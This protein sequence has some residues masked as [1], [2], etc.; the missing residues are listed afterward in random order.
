MSRKLEGILGL[1]DQTK[2]TL[3][4]FE[5]NVNRMGDKVI[6]VGKKA[7]VALAALGVTAV[8]VGSNY[9][10][11][12]ANVQAVTNSTDKEMAALSA[13]AREMG[14][15]TKFSASEAGDAF[16]ALGSAGMSAQE[17]IAAIPGVLA[18]AAAEGAGLSE[19]TEAV[20]A[21]MSMF[22]M[23][24]EESARVANLFA[25]GVSA[26]LQKLPDLQEA[27]KNTGKAAN[28]VNI[29]I[30]MTVALITEFA[31][32]GE[33]GGIA[34]THIQ[35]ALLKLIKPTG[36]LAETLGDANLANTEFIDLLEMLEERGY[37]A[38][39]AMQDLG[40]RGMGLSTILQIGSKSIR[41]MTE[42]LTGTETASRK[43]STEM[44]T[45][46]GDLLEAKAA[47]ED[48]GIAFFEA[49]GPDLRQLV[50]DITEDIGEFG[51]YIIDNKD[52]IAAAA[53]ASYGALKEGAEWLIDHKGAIAAVITVMFGAATVTKMWSM[54]TALK[55]M[56]ASSAFKF[57]AT[58]GPTGWLA[59][60]GIGAS[61]LAVKEFNDRYKELLDTGKGT[62]FDEIVGPM[63]PEGETDIVITITPELNPDF[64]WEK[65]Y[66]DQAA[67][68]EASGQTDRQVFERRLLTE[69]DYLGQRSELVQ[70]ADYALTAMM[71]EQ[72]AERTR[73]EVEAR[74]ASM[75]STV[76]Y[77]AALEVIRAEAQQATLDQTY[78][79][80]D[81]MNAATSTGS[82]VVLNTQITGDKKWLK[83]RDAF[84]GSALQ[85]V[86]KFVM[87]TVKQLVLESVGAQAVAAAV[88]AT[89]TTK[90][91]GQ[92]AAK[93]VGV[94]SRVALDAT[95]S[96][97]AVGAA[98]IQSV[99]MAAKV[100]NFYAGLGPF[101][102][103][104]AI[105]T[106]AGFVALIKGVVG[107]FAYA[108]EVTGGYGDRKDNVPAMLSRG[109]HV[110][111]AP[112]ARAIGHGRLDDM[113]R[114]GSIDS[115]SAG[116]AMMVKPEINIYPPMSVTEQFAVMMQEYFESG[117]GQD[118]IEDLFRHMVLQ[119]KFQG[120]F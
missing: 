62:T 77:Y 71:E 94:S 99:S 92:T 63:L 90:Q 81:A 16:Y 66:A 120:V 96:A 37:T 15:S 39:T 106:I 110:I 14:R 51:S 67:A 52:D 70:Q 117:L 102:I 112:A 41:E 75:D 107:N 97:S 5:N 40:A 6:S 42:D 20:V 18:L 35:Q 48:V 46:R 23:D 31:N 80:W 24:A 2:S 22:Q 30:E 38:Q 55:A 82:S 84:L 7:G 34:G 103:P 57:L 3:K 111:S 79:F 25:A 44:D 53:K 76:Q 68:A 17:S 49:I 98:S 8:V 47:A 1:S 78:M 11:S 87:N 61:A 65:I 116:G 13:S 113:D 26:G 74:V 29:P 114:T 105:A 33:K 21:A 64:D 50:D 100:A 115:G 72:Q 43:A 119:G 69:A 9:E 19:S 45:L 73:T 101:G 54:V 95:E 27:M 93:A 60:A 56:G 10:Q 58:L 104:L 36:I 86:T 59:A 108:G 12:M 109:E 88:V 118:A 91:T 4:G 89:E 28:Q 32:L 83:V 85:S